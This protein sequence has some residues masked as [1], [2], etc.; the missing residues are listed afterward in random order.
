MSTNNKVFR[1]LVTKGNKALATVGT[2]VDALADGQLGI[3]DAET[4]LAVA[5][6]VKKFFLAVGKDTDGDGTIDD[7][8]TSAGQE[9]QVNNFRDL[10]YTPYV[11]ATPM[12]FTITDIANVKPETD[13]T[14]KLELRN[15]EIYARQG[16]VQFTKTFSVRTNCNEEDAT[17]AK[18]VTLLLEAFNGDE[19]KM[20]TAVGVENLEEVEDSIKIT[21]NDIAIR[22]FCDINTRYVNTRQTVIIPSLVDDFNCSAKITITSQGNSEEGHGYDI[23]QKEYH[24]GGWTGKPGI[25]R[26]STAL[27]LAMPGFEYM[28]DE[29]GKYDQFHLVYDQF[30]TAGWGEYLNNL[31]TV[32]AVPTEDTITIAAVKTAIE[33][34]MPGSFPES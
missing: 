12:E 15:S 29:N 27:G 7:I 28:V 1:I 20:F 10:T 11:A 18:L 14:V 24:A 17:P 30:S 4:N 19:T 32:V 5:T 16:Y 22:R 2:N 6:P 13:Y 33:G 26:A 21:A 3:F 23:K 34:I 9:I 25:Y 8:V 31:M